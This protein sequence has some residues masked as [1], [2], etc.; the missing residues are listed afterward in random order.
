MKI[1]VISDKH[2]NIVGTMRHQETLAGHERSTRV[3]A[4]PEQLASVM[5]MPDD[6][7]N[8][9]VEELHKKIA[10]YLKK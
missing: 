9:S 1:T 10:Q 7:A 2:G 6:V 5:D 4:G 8:G 3:V